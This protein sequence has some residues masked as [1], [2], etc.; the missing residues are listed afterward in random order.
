MCGRKRENHGVVKSHIRTFFKFIT[1]QD[2]H[3]T[4]SEFFFSKFYPQINLIYKR[5]RKT[6]ST[7]LNDPKPTSVFFFFRFLLHSTVID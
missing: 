1:S 6:G 2:I 7:L 3:K 5:L 4:K